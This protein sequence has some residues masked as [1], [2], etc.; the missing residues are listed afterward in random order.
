MCR[1]IRS[2]VVCYFPWLT[3]SNG[4]THFFFPAEMKGIVCNGEEAAAH[5]SKGRSWLQHHSLC[6]SVLPLCRGC[7]GLW[8]DVLTWRAATIWCGTWLAGCCAY[9]N[10]ICIRAHP[11][12]TETNSKELAQ[13]WRTMEIPLLCGLNFGSCLLSK[14][15]S[16]SLINPLIVC[17]QHLKVLCRGCSL[18]VYNEG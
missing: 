6:S 10:H 11:T 2:Q 15:I 17:L 3:P 18:W 8:S 1:R 5:L 12:I 4:L 7:G 14:G 13:T 16:P 9:G